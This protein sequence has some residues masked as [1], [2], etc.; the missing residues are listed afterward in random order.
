MVFVAGASDRLFVLFAVSYSGQIWA[1]RVLV[2]VLPA[3]ALVLTKRICDELVRS[4]DV[5]RERR[6]AEAEAQALA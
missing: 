1:Y 6:A 4:E 2:W 3:V 5:E